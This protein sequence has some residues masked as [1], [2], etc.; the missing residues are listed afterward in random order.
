MSKRI[1]IDLICEDNAQESFLRPLIQRLAGERGYSARINVLSAGGG[2]PRVRASVSLWEKRVGS[3][4]RAAPDV[5]VVAH[6]AN[7]RGYSDVEQ[8]IRDWVSAERAS[9]LVP[10]C[11]NPHVERWYVLDQTGF[12]AVVG[13]ERLSIPDKCERHFYKNLLRN[14]VETA[15][16]L[17]PV[18]GIDFGP[19]LAMKIDLYRLSKKDASFKSFVETFSEK[20]RKVLPESGASP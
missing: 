11:P 18:G 4:D 5:L 3:G 13:G 15:G 1:V 14:A 7:C 20:L 10:A 2:A 9:I 16:H 17:S 8:R 12:L 19:D 6:D